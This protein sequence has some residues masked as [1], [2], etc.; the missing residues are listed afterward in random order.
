MKLTL[1][2][3]RRVVFAD[4]A[5]VGDVLFIAELGVATPH[6]CPIDRVFCTKC[7]LIKFFVR[8]ILVHIFFEESLGEFCRRKFLKAVS[9]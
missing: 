1:S 8:G 4:N 3:D 9:W 2:N 6:I 5:V 7:V